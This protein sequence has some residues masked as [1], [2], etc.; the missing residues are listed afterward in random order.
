MN[1]TSFLANKCFEYLLKCDTAKETEQTRAQFLSASNSSIPSKIYIQPPWSVNSEKFKSFCDGCGEC[2]TACKNGILILDKNGYP[3]V[4]FSRGSC[5]FCSVC[6]QSCPRKALQF[7]PSIPP[8]DIHA[9]IN[10]RC[11]IKNNVVCN[12]CVEQCEREAII[13]PRIVEKDQTPQVLTDSCN[14]CGTCLKACPVQAI[15]I[16]QSE[17][18]EQP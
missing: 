5:N 3:R 15:E 12:T 9:D 4:D 11:L 13:I 2:I 14:G 18:Q 1:L 8:W 6:A 7:D 17:Y 10:G 16:R